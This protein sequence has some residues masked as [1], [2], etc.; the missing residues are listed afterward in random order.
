MQM[1]RLP[2]PL[3]RQSHVLLC[4]CADEG[5]PGKSDDRSGMTVVWVAS[6]CQ[7]DVLT[8]PSDLVPQTCND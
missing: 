6:S 3:L 2:Q 4:V 7:R 1:A 8:S 5:A